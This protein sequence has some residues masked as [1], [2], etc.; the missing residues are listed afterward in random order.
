[1]PSPQYEVVFDRTMLAW[2]IDSL[3]GLTLNNEWLSGDMLLARWDAIPEDMAAER[4]AFEGEVLK[5]LLAIIKLQAW[6]PESL[7]VYFNLGQQW[8]PSA[9]AF[10][11]LVEQALPTLPQAEFIIL[12]APLQPQAT[13]TP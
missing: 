1:L 9:E 11:A 4:L 7:Q 6:T 13:P 12:P 2:T 5:A 3:G 8:N 10:L